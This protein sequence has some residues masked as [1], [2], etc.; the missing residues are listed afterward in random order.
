MQNLWV[1][2]TCTLRKWHHQGHRGVTHSD[3]VQ[4]FLWRL[5]LLQVNVFI[6]SAYFCRNTRISA[7][8]E[9]NQRHEPDVIRKR[10]DSNYHGPLSPLRLISVSLRP[11]AFWETS[12]WRHQS[13]QLYRALSLFPIRDRCDHPQCRYLIVI[14]VWL[15]RPVINWWPLMTCILHSYHEDPLS[16]FSQK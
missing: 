7:Q 4:L 13:P 16:S 12:S 8:V 15:C 5:R 9:C 3:C 10:G 1:S 2:L 6:E 14:T 11:T